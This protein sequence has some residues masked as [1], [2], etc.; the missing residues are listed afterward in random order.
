MSVSRGEA[1][2]LICGLAGRFS[3]HI[4]DIRHVI[5]A[6]PGVSKI[7]ALS[8]LITQSGPLF[9]ADSYVQE[10]PSAADIAEFTQLAAKEL[11][12]FNIAPK[13]ALVSHSNFGTGETEDA[14]KLREALAIVRQAMPNLEIDGEMH[15][16]AALSEAVSYTHLTLPTNREV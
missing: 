8:L 9:F 16:D 10:D 5:G 14:I 3:R 12:R 1:D 7:S 11:D 6:T 4:R 13:V 15:G 2:G